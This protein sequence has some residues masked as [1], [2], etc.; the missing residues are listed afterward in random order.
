MLGVDHASYWVAYPHPASP[1]QDRT[2]VVASAPPF[3]VIYTV[4]VVVRQL[5]R[6]VAV[7]ATGVDT[8]PSMPPPDCS[9][10]QD[11]TSVAEWEY[12]VADDAIVAAV[13]QYAVVAV[14][15]I[16]AEALLEQ[17]VGLV[18]MMTRPI[19]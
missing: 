11:N 18:T 6:V 10:S 13:G 7:V 8:Y 9:T 2:S 17:V 14:A 4:A 19:P 5:D 16:H 15:V 12:Y 1:D 3:V